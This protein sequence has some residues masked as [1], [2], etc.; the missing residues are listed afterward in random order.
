[1]LAFCGATPYILIMKTPHATPEKDSKMTSTE[2]LSA[3]VSRKTEIDKMLEAL[4]AKSADHFDADAEEINWGHV[5]N[6]GYIA[7]KLAEICDAI[8]VAR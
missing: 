7:D 2:A 3:F 4:A 5:G 1:M 6:L 8:G